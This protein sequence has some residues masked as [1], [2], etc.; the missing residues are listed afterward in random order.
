MADDNNNGG[1]YFN[2]MSDKSSDGKK[3]DVA[4]DEQ[5]KKTA[6]VYTDSLSEDDTPAKQKETP[7]KERKK[8]KK[9]D[10]IIIAVLAVSDVVLLVSVCFSF[11]MLLVAAANKKTD[12][13]ASNFYDVSTVLD[14]LS[15]KI[16]DVDFPNGI[17]NRFKSIYSEN[18]DVV[19]W[20]KINDTAV[21]FPVMKTLDGTYYERKNFYGEFDRRGSIWMDARCTTGKGKDSLQKITIIYG[22]NLTLDECIF[23]DVTKYRDVGFYKQHPVI[24]FDTL[25][26]NYKWKAFACFITTVNP[27][28]DNGNYFNYLDPTI[29]DDRTID[30]ANE[31]LSRSYFVNNSV[32]IAADDKLLVLSTCVYDFNTDDIYIETR[33]VL[34]CRLVREGESEDVDVSNVSANENRRMP[35]IWY[36]RSGKTNP[37]ASVAVFSR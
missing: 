16:K 26:D 3:S 37:Y 36:D 4:V 32:D 25:Y 8:M 12:T 15:P 23:R 2:S 35:Q 17:Q 33:C 27:D 6:D 5:T 28:Y 34:V 29:P 19:G 7:K 21:D 9:S 20:I 31:C 22:H 1:I 10:K 24:E 14:S 18:S 13:S 11:L 30:Y